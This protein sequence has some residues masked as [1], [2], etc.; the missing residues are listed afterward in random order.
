[1]MEKAD[2]G[3]PRAAIWL[4]VK[5]ILTA[6]ILYFLYSQIAHH[7]EQIAN[8]SWQIDFAMTGLAVV[9]GALA[10][11]LIASNWRRLM[12]AFGYEIPMRRAFRVFY[13]SDLGRYIPG[14]VWTLVGFIYLARKEGVS[15]EDAT[16]SFVVSQLFTI[17][18]SFL[19]VALAVQYDQRLLVDQLALLGEYSAHILT[20]VMLMG[21]AVV[22]FW[23][24]KVLSVANFV[25]RRFG[26]PGIDFRLDKR[27]AL[28]LFLRYFLGWLGYGAAFYL[29]VNSVAPDSGL[30]LIAAC[31]IFSAAYQVGYLSIFAPGGL[32]PRELVMG[33]ML[34]PYLGP[35]APAVAIGARLWV[36]V[37]EIVV[38]LIALSIRK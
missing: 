28:Q 9:V 24:P 26:R 14:K 1:M 8:H 22:I 17:P 36:I 23:L 15:P 37:I 4:A 20:G 2:K 29:F 16:A 10:L 27:V 21:A 31:G 12:A 11:L 35:L 3:Q 30:G 5:I 25:L 34:V 32:G 13:L 33:L 38:A 19:V 7:W 18:A 6:V